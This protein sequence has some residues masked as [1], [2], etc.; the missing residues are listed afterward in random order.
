MIN[1]LGAYAYC[2]EDISKIENYDK[3]IADKTQTWHCHHKAELLPCGK[4]SSTTLQKFGLYWNQPADRLIFLTNS[5]HSKIHYTGKNNPRF[6]KHLSEETKR[7]IR[8]KNK[9]RKMSEEVCRRMSESH[10]G[11]SSG[12]KGKQLSEITRMKMS[13]VRKGVK[14]S[15]DTKRRMSEAAK[16]R[17]AKKRGKLCQ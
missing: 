13:K 12:M 2:S 11:K 17:E 4:Y 5:E 1:I 6:G 8:L 10:K 3:A 7:K 15:E 16:I 14:K 9:G